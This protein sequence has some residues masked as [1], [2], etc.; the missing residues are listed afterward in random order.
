MNFDNMQMK[1]SDSLE[2]SDDANIIFQLF[3]GEVMDAKMA[4]FI[5]IHM[6]N[7]LFEAE[8]EDQDDQAGNNL[9]GLFHP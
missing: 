6:L 4:N 2:S 9:N 8:V 5:T 3:E 7:D 1:T